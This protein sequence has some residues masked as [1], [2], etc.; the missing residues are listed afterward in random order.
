MNNITL[1]G[2]VGKTPVIKDFESGSKVCKFSLAVKNPYKPTDDPMWINVEAWG[3][4]A[5]RA[6]SILTAGREVIV[7]GY[8]ALEEFESKKDGKVHTRP[9]VKLLYFTACGAKPKAEAA[10]LADPPKVKRS[11]KK[12]A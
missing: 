6:V 8:L 4:V 2:H 3:N 9:V 11:A 5:E 1:S 12:A 7:Q 10:P